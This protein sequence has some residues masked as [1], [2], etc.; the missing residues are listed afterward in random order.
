[1]LQLLQ[2]NNWLGRMVFV[3]PTRPEKS[4]RKLQGELSAAFG[5][6]YEQAKKQRI[7]G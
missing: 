1:M 7:V 2:V 5:I 6:K 3:A 4:L